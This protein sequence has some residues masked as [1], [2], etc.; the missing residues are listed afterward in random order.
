MIS[1]VICLSPRRVLHLCNLPRV[2]A[3]FRLISIARCAFKSPRIE[4]AFEGQ[5][6][7]FTVSMLLTCIVHCDTEQVQ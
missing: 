3:L 1:A 5:N 4:F 7:K 6:M 2:Y